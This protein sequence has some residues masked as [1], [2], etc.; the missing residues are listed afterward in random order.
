[1]DSCVHVSTA[2]VGSDLP[3]ARFWD[4]MP[5]SQRRTDEEIDNE[6][7]LE[8]CIIKERADSLNDHDPY[9]DCCMD[10]HDIPSPPK[11]P[12]PAHMPGCG[13]WGL[14]RSPMRSLIHTFFQAVQMHHHLCR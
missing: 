10:V 14:Q 8:D 1:M 2:R 12:V 3:M 6:V 7:E 9:D 11:S 13:Y 4:G 5:I